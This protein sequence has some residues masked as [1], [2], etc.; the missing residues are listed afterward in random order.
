MQAERSRGSE[1]DVLVRKIV[2]FER[3]NE[4][5]QVRERFRLA[6]EK[7]L[8]LAVVHIDAVF[9]VF[10]HAADGKRVAERAENVCALEKFAVCRDGEGR[11]V[12]R[13]EVLHA[14]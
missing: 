10:Q 2:V 8:E 1:I 7:H 5:V 4:A 3:Q 11:D 9:I 14:L 13:V 6:N 12:E